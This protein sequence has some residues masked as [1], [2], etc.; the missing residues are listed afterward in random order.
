M[1]VCWEEVD[2]KQNKKSKVAV[3]VMKMKQCKGTLNFV[4]CESIMSQVLRFR[5]DP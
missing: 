5:K 4:L 1:N 2:N 3:S